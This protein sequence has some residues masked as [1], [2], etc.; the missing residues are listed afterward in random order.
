MGKALVLVHGKLLAVLI[1]CAMTFGA[2]ARG[3]ADGRAPQGAEIDIP[4]GG[5]LP[6]GARFRSTGSRGGLKPRATFPKSPGVMPLGVVRRVPQQYPTIQAGVTASADGDTVLVSEGTYFETVD[7][8]G[9]SVVVASLYLLDRDTV[10]IVRTVVDGSRAADSGSVVRF[11]TGEDTNSVLCGFTVRGGRGTFIPDLGEDHGG[12]VFLWASSGRLVRNIITGNTAEGPLAFGGGVSTTGP[13][14]TGQTLIMED[15]IITRNTVNATS[16]VGFGGGVAILRS[17]F[18]LTGNLFER[19]S[20]RGTVQAGGSA[21]IVFLGSGNLGV[22]QGNIIRHNVVL[23][24]S[25]AYATLC[26]AQYQGEVVIDGNVIEHNAVISTYLQAYGSALYLDDPAPS[27]EKVVSRN[28][29]R[30]NRTASTQLGTLG[31]AVILWGPRAV[32]AENLVRDNTSQAGTY[33]YGGG[34]LALDAHVTIASNLI[35]NNTLQAGN[36]AYGG[37]IYCIRWAGAIENN[38]I[39]GNRG[40]NGGGFGHAG[41][42]PS[43]LT[44]AIINNTFSGNVADLGGGLW[45]GSTTT[46]VILNTIFWDDSSTDG[47]ISSGG[48]VEVHY[49][50]IEGGWSGGTGNIN[51]NPLFADTLYRLGNAS[52]S[53]GA[54][55]DSIQVAGT[56]YR[57][58]VR[59]VSATP[60][61]MPA[62]S[63][64]D[65]GARENSRGTPT[66]VG[67]AN[68]G[69]P[70]AFGLAQNYPN[71]F[72]PSTTIRFDIPAGAAGRAVL[73]VYDVLGRELATLLDEEAKPGAHDVT[74]DAA[75]VASGV[76]F[77]R[78]HV[79]ADGSGAGGFVATRKMILM[80]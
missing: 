56:W 51:A 49:S 15:N 23:G 67:D 40:G 41:T 33:A 45:G 60:R 21:A 39:T 35:Q 53:I 80:Q 3:Q 43:G 18:R 13:T 29:I 31:G 78:L 55:G 75:G 66:A 2:D 48:T 76:Y 16:G 12:G 26:V 34:V 17:Q 10:H 32:F 4:S 25:S 19:D 64:P 27:W 1:A 28:V 59:D 30:R 73:R 57:A 36:T 14:N 68:T 69:L 65:M 38:I 50:N 9:K 63:R 42:A 58:P 7:F 5:M 47:E 22:I 8:L 20:A 24:D 54:G 71:P 44:Q 11:V 79:S 62:N 37:G 52:P 61:P 74:W 6:L 70:G 46:S 72:N 77:Y